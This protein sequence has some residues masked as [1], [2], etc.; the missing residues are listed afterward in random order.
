KSGKNSLFW[1]KLETNHS[2]W[3]CW[4]I[5]KLPN[6]ES[7]NLLLLF[8]LKEKSKPDDNSEN[9]AKDKRRPDSFLVKKWALFH[10]C[11]FL[12]LTILALLLVT[13]ADQIS[14]VSLSLMGLKLFA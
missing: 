13:V 7:T 1:F 9:T 4:Q 8:K 14:A 2:L 12:V 3:I 5:L 10:M 6:F 11:I